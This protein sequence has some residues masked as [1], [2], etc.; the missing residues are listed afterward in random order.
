MCPS[1]QSQESYASCSKH[2]LF[3]IYLLDFRGALP[4]ESSRP[5]AKDFRVLSYKH[6]SKLTIAQ[7]ADHQGQ[8]ESKKDSDKHIQGAS[9]CSVRTLLVE[10]RSSLQF[11][12]E[13]LWFSFY[14]EIQR[15]FI[16]QSKKKNSSENKADF[17]GS[18][19]KL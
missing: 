6:P 3:I 14:E 5:C 16:Q 7:T 13:A 10:H 4:L 19:S 8:Q 11:N 9:Q 12:Q 18:C 15:I 17:L 1:E 2:C